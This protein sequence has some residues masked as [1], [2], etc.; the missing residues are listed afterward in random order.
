MQEVLNNPR[1]FCEA[2]N[3]DSFG[4]LLINVQR[5]HGLI[6]HHTTFGFAALV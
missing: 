3:R 5:Y 1:N 4:H 6:S 2:K